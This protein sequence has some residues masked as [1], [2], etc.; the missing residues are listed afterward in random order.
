MKF[1]IVFPLVNNLWSVWFTQPKPIIWPQG[2][3]SMGYRFTDTD[4][5]MSEWPGLKDVNNHSSPR[6]HISI[7]RLDPSAKFPLI[8]NPVRWWEVAGVLF[9]KV[10]QV[11]KREARGNLIRSLAGSGGVCLGGVCLESSSQLEIYRAEE[12]FYVYLDV[13][14]AKWS[15]LP[16]G[17]IETMVLNHG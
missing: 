2:S 1:H 5:S 4:T 7:F 14:D 8:A 9:K 6:C 13:T 12:R 11:L 17:T 3:P 15:S 10:E 16:D